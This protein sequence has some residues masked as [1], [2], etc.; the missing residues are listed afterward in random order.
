MLFYVVCCLY[1]VCKQ[2]VVLERCVGFFFYFVECEVSKKILMCVK[3]FLFFLLKLILICKDE[4]IFIE[5]CDFVNG[6]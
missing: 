6:V 2:N 3:M 1:G 5:F 4:K